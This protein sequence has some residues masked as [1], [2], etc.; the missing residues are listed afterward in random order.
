MVEDP[1]LK[2]EE[3]EKYQQF[4]DSRIDD[5]LTDEERTEI[6]DMGSTGA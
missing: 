3:P 4:I 2:E 5:P 6:E 1:R